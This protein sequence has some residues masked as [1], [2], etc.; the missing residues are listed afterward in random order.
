MPGERANGR[1]FVEADVVR[2]SVVELACH[3]ST[4]IK[5]VIELH[6]IKA[7]VG[8]RRPLLRAGNGITKYLALD[9]MGVGL[10]ETSSASSAPP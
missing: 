6:L 7:L 1:T 4:T 3:S 5:P 9:P 10:M 8:I 2:R